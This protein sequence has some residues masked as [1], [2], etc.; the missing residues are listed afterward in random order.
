M[1][2]DACGRP[3]PCLGDGHLASVRHAQLHAFMPHLDLQL[4]HL[5]YC[6][7]RAYRRH[8][9]GMDHGGSTG[10]A[11]I[12]HAVAL[13]ASLSATI[14]GAAPA[15]LRHLRGWHMLSRQ[16]LASRARLG[17]MHVHHEQVRTCPTALIF[18]NSPPRYRSAALSK[19]RAMPTFCGRES[20]GDD[21]EA[22]ALRRGRA[23]GQGARSKERLARWATPAGRRSH[24]L[25]ACRWFKAQPRCW[26]EKTTSSPAPCL[27]HQAAHW[28]PPCRLTAPRRG[29]PSL[30][31]RCHAPVQ[32]S[33]KRAVESPGAFGCCVGNRA[34]RMRREVRCRLCGGGRRERR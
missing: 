29:L 5:L 31:L 25:S 28:W 19:S 12:A 11:C 24:T 2:S 14:A 1:D 7:I 15:R 23:G 4:P 18:S 27:R 30:P 20:G 22:Q 33:A 13:P 10:S 6:G 9:L 34:A 26:H 16:P 3:M 32:G 8:T 21:S 17:H